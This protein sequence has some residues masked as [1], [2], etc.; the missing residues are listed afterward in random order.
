MRLKARILDWWCWFTLVW[1][2]QFKHSLMPWRRRRLRHLFE[3]CFLLNGYA[4]D[5]QGFEDCF[6]VYKWELDEYSFPEI[7]RGVNWFVRRHDEVPEAYDII[8]AI[9]YKTFDE[10]MKAD[11]R[12]SWERKKA[13]QPIGSEA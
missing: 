12:E 1:L 9:R 13:P 10:Y 2:D 3:V 11:L 4:I 5:D 7:L 6:D 8:K